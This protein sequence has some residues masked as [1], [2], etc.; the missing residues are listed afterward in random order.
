ML[1]GLPPGW[2]PDPNIEAIPHPRPQGSFGAI[3]NRF[4][5]MREPWD[6]LDPSVASFRNEIEKIGAV[7]PPPDQSV[8]VALRQ[9]GEVTRTGN[10][11][12]LNGVPVPAGPEQI[13]VF[14]SV[15]FRWLISPAAKLYLIGCRNPSLVDPVDYEALMVQ[16]GNAPALHHLLGHDALHV[17]DPLQQRLLTYS[18]DTHRQNLVS[19]QAKHIRLFWAVWIRDLDA[20]E[21]LTRET[22]AKDLALWLVPPDPRIKKRLRDSAF[23][24]LCGTSILSELERLFEILE[25][26]HA[27]SLVTQ[28]T[29]KRFMRTKRSL[30]DVP[31]DQS[32]SSAYV[33]ATV[34]WARFNHSSMNRA[35]DSTSLDPTFRRLNT[36]LL[37]EKPA[38]VANNRLRKPFKGTPTFQFIGVEQQYLPIVALLT[39]VQDLKRL[40]GNYFHR[41]PH[42]K[43]SL[44][45][46]EADAIRLAAVIASNVHTKYGQAML[47][48]VGSGTQCEETW[49][50]NELQSLIFNESLIEDYE[51]AL[52]LFIQNAGVSGQIP[53]RPIVFA[54]DGT[55]K[56]Y[57][58]LI[59]AVK[60]RLRK[61]PRMG[62]A[63]WT[64]SFHFEASMHP[65][66]EIE[67]LKKCITY[68]RYSKKARKAHL[69]RVA[70]AR[71]RGSVKEGREF[72][73]LPANNPV[74]AVHENLK[75]IFDRLQY[76]EKLAARF[77][78]PYEDVLNIFLREVA[79]L[80]PAVSPITVDPFRNEQL[81]ATVPP[82]EIHNVIERDWCALRMRNAPYRR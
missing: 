57:T 43:G 22:T 32:S 10:L 16:H 60:S 69:K 44:Q 13:R 12:E 39:I 76:P 41:V 14:I 65:N 30:K 52:G 64:Q 47:G 24:L 59:K 8:L 82:K 1:D 68:N 31:N 15:R 33:L 21:R 73:G 40:E 78:K 34:G 9:L 80:L 67:F 48:Y 4:A 42:N 51:T 36:A 79:R 3:G 23:R 72:T 45:R 2:L 19:L 75:I 50:R 81:L 11:T 62:E 20:V 7:L 74:E 5:G 70:K 6:A 54:G 66:A 17:T 56:S 46:P 77:R 55:T 37:H 35:V 71:A 26:G 38:Q 63:C 58:S 49:I 53:E 27:N 18:I 29:I 25:Y 61:L 28:E